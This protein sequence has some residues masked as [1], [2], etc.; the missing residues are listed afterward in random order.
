MHL[1]ENA[2]VVPE[3]QQPL[4]EAWFDG[5]CEPVNPGGHAAYGAVVLRGGKELLREGGYVGHGE[6]MSNNV[7]E[8]AGVLR[9]LEFLATLDGPALIR[10]DSK[11]VISQLT[12]EWKAKKGLYLDRYRQAVAL[13]ARLGSRVRL[14]WVG[15]D[16]N[17]LCDD[18]SKQVLRDR[19]IRFRIQRE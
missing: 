10:G 6:G 14:E 1:S 18:L 11:L 16:Q 4:L 9:V 12:G 2:M 5:V 8:Y 7:A 17:S 3:N 15:R 13:V 19:G